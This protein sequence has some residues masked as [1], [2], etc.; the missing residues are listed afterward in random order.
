MKLID[1][2][3]ETDFAYDGFDRRVR[4]IETENGVGQ[5]N[6]VF[7]WD[8]NQIAQR[9]DRTGATVGRNYFANGFETGGKDY[10]YTKDHLGSI[11]EVVASDGTTVEAVYDYSPWGEVSKIAGTGAESDFLYTGHFYHDESDLHL[12]LFR[13]YNPELG[14]WLSRDPIAENGGINLYAYVGNDPILRYDPLGLKWY[15]DAAIGGLN[16]LESGLSFAAG[17]GDS[18]T[19]GLTSKIS[20][21]LN[22]AI[23]G[24]GTG[25]A[26]D[27]KLK[28]SKSH[29]AGQ[30]A[31]LGLGGGRLVYAGAAK[32]S[33]LIQTAR[34]ATMANA[35][36]ASSFRNGLKK[37]FRLN[38]FSK[39]RVYPFEKISTKYGDPKSI[40][41]AA[42]RTDGTLNALGADLV[43]GSAYSLSKDDGG[44]C[45]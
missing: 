16:A 18:A 27:K 2:R 23:Y 31:S 30:W 19:F 3:H 44:D 17:V 4:I 35:R 25:D 6:K 28:C 20:N 36:T 12:T 5:S 34:G 40:I 8:D 14:M 42:G 1:G 9:R 10:Y 11:R 29:T 38:P 24:D 13:A 43:A 45:D 15:H 7:L 37:A 22:D 26:V 33:S 21:G 32:G 39:F 41:D